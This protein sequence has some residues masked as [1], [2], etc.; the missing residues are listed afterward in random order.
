[1]VR[2]FLAV[3]VALVALSP[4]IAARKREKDPVFGQIDSIVKSLSQISGLSE[5]HPVDY[6]S[7]SKKQL[8]RFLRKRLKKTLRPEEIEADELTLKMFGLVPQD[9]DLKKSTLDLLTEQAAAFYDYDEKKLFLL[10][11]SPLGDEAATLAHELSHALADQHF[12]LEHFMD[13]SPENDDENLARTAVVEGQA[14]WLMLAYSLVKA[15]KPPVPSQEVL[16]SVEDSGEASDNDYPILKASPL[17]IKQSLLFPYTDGIKFFDAVF[18]RMG[19]AAFATVF[20][21]PPLGS[22]QIFHPERYFAHEK[23]AIPELPKLNLGDAGEEIT[24]GSV[25]EFDHRMLLWQYMS[26]QKAVSLSPHLQGAQFRLTASGKKGRP[27]LEYV[28]RWDSAA[29]ATEYFNAY[30]TVLRAKWKRCDVSADSVAL[31]A[32]SGDD[33]FFVTHLSADTLVSVEGLPE[34]VSW[35]GLLTPV[36]ESLAAAAVPSVLRALPAERTSLAVKEASELQSKLN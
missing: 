25:G 23:L 11:G 10:Q 36:A 29:S 3:L 13:E 14:S 30:K 19:K 17:Y 16:Q 24:E 2:R 1:M 21:R 35:A 5:E 31:F 28:S 7:I 33:G 20:T 27:V 15:G 8:A 6:G 4:F 18:K 22:A 26:Q 12:N 32:G 9:F 34:R